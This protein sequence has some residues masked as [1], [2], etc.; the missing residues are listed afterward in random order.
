[1]CI[2]VNMCIYVYLYVL[3]MS[4]VFVVRLCIFVGYVT[5]QDQVL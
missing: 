3:C 1:M 4:Y 5:C 2:H